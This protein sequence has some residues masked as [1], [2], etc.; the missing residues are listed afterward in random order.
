MKYEL[1]I[2]DKDGN[3]DLYQD[4]KTRDR[5]EINAELMTSHPCVVKTE[6]K[7]VDDGSW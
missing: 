4:Y 1:W 2:I 5:A 6:I 7:E 3:L